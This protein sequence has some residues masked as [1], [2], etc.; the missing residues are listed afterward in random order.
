KVTTWLERAH[1]LGSPTLRFHSGFYRSE[2]DGSAEIIKQEREYMLTTL[3]AVAPLAAERNIRIAIENTSD[4]IADEF[5]VIF[6]ELQ[7]PNVGIYLDITNPQVI[8]D[9]PVSAISRMAPLAFGGDV[10][11]FRLDSNWT[12]D[13]FHRRGYTVTFVY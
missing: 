9:E 8:Y 5:L 7:A 1:A 2:I 13:N 6:E 11:D 3:R 4:Y 10:K 12:A